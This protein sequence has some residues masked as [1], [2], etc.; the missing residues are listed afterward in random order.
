MPVTCRNSLEPIPA[1]VSTVA[2]RV[3]DGCRH[4]AFRNNIAI[5]YYSKAEL[6][7]SFV[8]Q[9]FR[10][11][12]R[13]STVRTSNLLIPGFLVF[14]T[15]NLCGFFFFTQNWDI[16]DI[17]LRVFFFFLNHFSPENGNV[18]KK[19]AFFYFCVA[20]RNVL[21]FLL[22]EESSRPVGLCGRYFFFLN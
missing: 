21:V 12:R 22:R 16:R 10:W 19:V 2:N 20:G 15:Q 3:Q 1:W 8:L 14:V 4:L 9:F 13:L 17:F 6:F 5:V 7:V 18:K 11:V